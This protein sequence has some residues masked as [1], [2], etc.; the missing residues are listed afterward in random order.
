MGKLN[1]KAI[2]E[3]FKKGKRPTE[4]DFSNLIDSM[5]NI[6]DEGFD[7]TPEDG[8]KISQLMG[9]GRLLSF[10]ENIAAEDP[11]WFLEMD[12]SSHK[13]HFGA[14]KIAAERVLTLGIENNAPHTLVVGINN[15]DPRYTLDVAGTI[16]SESRLG[17]SGKL[18]VEADGEW[19]DIT[20]TLTGCRAIEIMAGVGGQEDG[21]YALTHAIALN[22]FN[23]TSSIDYQ[24]QA[25][26]GNR[27]NRIELQ[28]QSVPKADLFSFKLQMRVACPYCKKG[29]KDSA[30]KKPIYIRYYLTDLWTDY[31]MDDDD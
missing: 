26:Y 27:C 11:K 10:Y 25:Y 29:E 19:H 22:T 12:K 23:G 15:A 1:R 4:E 24:Q 7:K 17:R 13:L 28:W 2:R 20:A 14:P 16:A 6:L 18:K 9:K 3:Q 31:F 21:K 30:N 8:L 5:V